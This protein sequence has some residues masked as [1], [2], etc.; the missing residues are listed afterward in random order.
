MV[1]GNSELTER[2]RS[3][4]ESGRDGG[5]RRTRLSDVMQIIKHG[6][7]PITLMMRRTKSRLRKSR[8]RAAP[9]RKVLADGVG[10]K[11]EAGTM[12]LCKVD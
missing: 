2:V 5:A 8:S 1:D 10:A 7:R 4:T 3:S 11:D 9:K 6:E 12:V